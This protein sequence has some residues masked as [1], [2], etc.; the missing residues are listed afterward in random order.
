MKAL[1]IQG[2]LRERLLGVLA[3][4]PWFKTLPPPVLE[5]VLG[6]AAALHYDPG[7]VVV[8]QGE[9]SD[10]FFLMLSG[11]A[12]VLS[13]QKEEKI[14]VGRLRPP[15]SFGEVGLL[16][17][18]P[19]TA[20]ISAVESL[21]VL[22]FTAKSFDSMVEKIP[23]FGVGALRGLASRLQHVTTLVPL[24]EDDARPTPEARSLLPVGFLQRHRVLPMKVEGATVTLGCVEDPTSQ[25]LAAVRQQ[26]PGM[27]LRLVRIRPQL[28]DETLAS[29]AGVEGWGPAKTAQA[30][31][32]KAR[33][34]PKLDR[35]L[36]RA[37]SEGAS[38]LP[39]GANQQP[40][41]RIDGESR[42]IDDLPALGEDEV[43][44]LL[45]PVMD[46]R[47]KAEFRAD[48]DTDF[49]YS[50]PGVARFRVNLFRD[51]HG[52]G[53]AFRQIPSK[54][55]SLEQLGL[56]PVV[57][58]FCELSKGLVLVTGATGSGKSTT[59]AA[60]VDHINRT[61]S[62]H[63]LTIEDP[64]EFVHPS[65]SSFVNQREVGGHTSSVARAL[66]AALREDPNIVLVGELRDLETVALALEMATTGHLVFAT[67]HTSSAVGTIDRIIDLFPHDQ[68][69]KVRSTLADGLKGVISQVLLKKRGGGRL[70]AYEV[71]AVNHAIANL[72][73]EGKAT[74]IPTAMISSKAQGNSQLND[75]LVKLVEARK[76]D[77]EEALSKAVDKLDLTKRLKPGLLPAGA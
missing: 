1:E 67:L 69:P 34:S 20:T 18:Q 60:M 62:K 71:L 29:R 41:G 70:G 13:E 21:S 22:K 4:S 47:N 9:P 75:E 61:Q 39:L 54:I 65:Q 12:A 5:Q 58:S 57:R 55:V 45:E 77:F 52:V 40:R 32:S 31:G 76:V 6:A 23:G 35:L 16:L 30:S 24:P 26:L 10:S 11:T 63:I 17:S 19:R 73:R 43:F 7:E 33:C 68:Q 2:E 15:A 50:V 37:A 53:A 8:R 74:Q 44:A 38:D 46:E 28:I 59:L 66:R 64:V 25:A 72:I 56:P 3:N 48:N 14:A 49:A 51:M 36:E 27:E 42:R